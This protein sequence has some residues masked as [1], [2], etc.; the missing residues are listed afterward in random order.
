MTSSTI[1]Q[2]LTVEKAAARCSVSIHTMRDW[3]D[4]GIVPT[5]QVL[6]GGRRLIA[7]PDLA[8]LLESRR[9]P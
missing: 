2:H 9:R 5:T 6:P 1:P 4:R 7:E 8:E 3:I